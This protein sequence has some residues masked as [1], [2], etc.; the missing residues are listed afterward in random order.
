MGWVAAAGLALNVAGQISEAKQREQYV[1]N[2]KTEAAFQQTAA[3]N[4]QTFQ[5]VERDAR[6]KRVLATQR[7]MFAS[8]GVDPTS[9]SAAAYR[10]SSIGEA[11]LEQAGDDAYGRLSDAAYQ[12]RNAALDQQKTYIQGAR[13]IG[14][15][16]A[17]VQSALRYKRI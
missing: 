3:K 17:V 12:N 9:G 15:G 5:Q 2:Q 11:A 8:S 13:N 4:A 7:A 16:S 14:I 10:N 1:D 6:L